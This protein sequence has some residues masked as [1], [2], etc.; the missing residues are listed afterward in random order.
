MNTTLFNILNGIGADAKTRQDPNTLALLNKTVQALDLG[1]GTAYDTSTAS[2][3]PVNIMRN[4][5]PAGSIA[6]STD[7]IMQLGV[8][9]I[10][11]VGG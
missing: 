6:P 7:S 10:R 11:K 2:A 1:L 4:P 8:T 9:D 3:T 5:Y